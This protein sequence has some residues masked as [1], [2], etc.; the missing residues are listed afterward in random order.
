MIFRLRD[1]G[2]LQEITVQVLDTDAL[3]E[4]AAT[5]PNAAT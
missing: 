3:I 1:D 2:V 5:T 4:V